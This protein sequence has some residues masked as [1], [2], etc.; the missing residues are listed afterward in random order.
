MEQEERRGR[1]PG[2]AELV[3]R[4]HYRQKTKQ[5][6]EFLENQGIKTLS[7]EEVMERG[8]TRRMERGEL[9]GLAVQIHGIETFYTLHDVE[10]AEARDDIAETVRQLLLVRQK[11][12]PGHQSEVVGLKQNQDPNSRKSRERREFNTARGMM[13]SRPEGGGPLWSGRG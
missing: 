8:W 7:P 1:I 13:S 11:G 6:R 4:C 9:R 10:E 5:L 3:V 2:L 12:D